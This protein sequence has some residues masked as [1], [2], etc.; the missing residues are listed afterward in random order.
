MKNHNCRFC[1]ATLTQVFVDLGM[2]PL[3]NSFV[4][5]EDFNKEVFYPLRAYVCNKCFLVQLVQYESPENIFKDYPYFSSYS[6]TYLNHAESYVNS[7][8]KKF[9]FDKKSLVI[10]I[11]S[12][13]G[14]LLQYFKAK[15]IPVLGIEPACNVADAA[16]KKGIPAIS[17]F[18]GIETAKELIFEG[19]R[20]DLLIGNNILAHIPNLNEFVIGMK[21]VLKPKG[22][23]TIEV[24]H[25]LKLI[26]LNQF[27][28]I[29]HEHLS[30]FSLSTLKK[31]LEAHKL[32]IFDVEEIPTH[33]GSIRIYSRHVEYS[34][35]K[36]NKHV[37]ALL[38]KEFRFGLLS[39]RGYEGFREKVEDTKRKL[40]EFLISTKRAGKKVVCY[41]APAK[42]NTMLNYCQVSRD[43]VNFTVDV[44]PYKQGL[45]LPG[46]HIPI[47]DPEKIRKEKPDY[48]LILPWNLKNE[49]MEQMRFVREWG[50]KFVVAVPKLK[51]YD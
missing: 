49:I 16:R 36:V 22:I 24:P 11:G 6:K 37:N 34:D 41:G 29:Y 21:L 18:F 20:P 28:T 14:Y 23:I 44:N 17:K 47:E 10:E 32:T 1:E 15:R 40:V 27:D 19:K 12:N 38:E 48:L 33:G 5:L 31:I 7:I 35:L 26:K 4:R 50:G 3:A 45:Y 2:S 25:L 46:T 9:E 42:G 8:M 39:W 13:D 43:L 30:Y 51:I